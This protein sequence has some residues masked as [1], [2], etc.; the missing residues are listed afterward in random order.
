MKYRILLLFL[1]TCLF[2][3]VIVAG[4][5][6]S[7]DT[8][9]I[10]NEPGAFE[11]YTLFAPIYSTTT[12]LIDMEGRIVNKWES[13]F[14][15]GQSVYL[16]EN[17]NL[18]R[19]AHPGPQSNE[20]FHGGGAGGRVEE[21]TW[22][23]ELAWTFSYSSEE[24]LLHHDIAVL[25]SGNI[26]MLAWERKSPAEA[27][28]AGRNPEML[29]SKGL[30]PD[31]VIE[32]EPAGSTAGNIVWEWHVWDHLIQ[33]F[34]DDKA[35]FGVVADHPE[36]IDINPV[37]W[38]VRL[39]RETRAKL[40][41]LG[42]LGSTRGRE[43]PGANPDWNH[44][45]S[46]DYIEKLD[47]IV[48]SVLGFNE[49]WIIDHGT[50]T[51]EAAGHI[52]GR[53]GRGGDLLYRWGN[54]QVWE[55]GIDSDQQLF[56]QHDAQWITDGLPGAG[57]LLVFN[58]GRGR[59]NGDYSS[60][61]EIPL[62]VNAAGHYTRTSGAPFGP[63]APA[64][65]FTATPKTDF[66][67]GH[68]SGA[69]RLPNGNTL[70]CS[71]E[72][73]TIFEVTEDGREVWR[74]VNPVMGRARPVSGGPG[75]GRT[76]VAGLSNCVFRACRYGPD[77][78]GLAGKELTGGRTIEELLTVMPR[79]AASNQALRRRA[80]R[81]GGRVRSG[82]VAPPDTGS[83][84]VIDPA[85]LAKVV[86]EGSAIAKLAGGMRFTEGPVWVSDGGYLLFSD[87]PSDE[88]KKW[89]RG[90]LTT[91]RKPSR[92]ASGNAL[93]HKGRL[94]ICEQES[95]SVTRTDN[96]GNVET[97]AASFEGKRLNSPNDLA[98]RSDGTIWFT[99]PPYGLK[100]RTRE[101]EANYV[102][103]LRPGVTEPT[104]AAADF[105]RPNGLCLSPD[106]KKLYIA[107]SGVPRNIRVFDVRADGSLRSGRVFCRIDTGAPDG[108][109]CD[110]DGRLYSTAGDGLHVYL[111][112]GRLIGRIP[113]PERPSNLCFGG[114]DGKTLFITACTS[115]YAVRLRVGGM[116]SMR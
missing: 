47:Q 70:I 83:M 34:D 68:I 49:I 20:T 87:I 60:V 85:E 5:E 59:K 11:G 86:P 102:F 45:N 65:T 13:E 105:D 112:D 19:T 6:E 101:M 10:L 3:P 91:F 2:V 21:F 77:Y 57:N 1:A 79:S 16:L 66:Y 113:V 32:V 54:P 78:P 73:G 39:S 72:N 25:P 18:L 42:Y 17:G 115:L 52:G 24:H 33:D 26:L 31:H 23:G 14:E 109:R 88:I 97:L 98:I 116:R 96:N 22:D 103:R 37:D 106:E 36:L 7:K 46:I 90:Q 95:R 99:D 71:G 38:T 94:V 27:V 114:A 30:W 43:R 44:I 82:D 40:E 35:G 61:D 107:D 64:W 51:K 104:I 74:Y 53:C 8:G 58:N 84:V 48:L 80:E 108:I 41:A 12:F 75:Q 63:A 15:P 56:A 62:P 76:G 9:L 67:S 4:G 100:D 81:A 69:Q 28:A 55:T 110:R 50:T 93:D 89:Y 29:G 92:E 111:P